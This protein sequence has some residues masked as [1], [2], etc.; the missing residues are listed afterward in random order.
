MKVQNGSKV[1]VHYTGK[2]EDGTIFDTSDGREPLAFTVGEGQMIPGFEKGVMDLA[3]GEKKTVTIPPEEAYG[4]PQE[5]MVLTVEKDKVFPPE[6]D[7]KVG[8]QYNLTRKDGGTLPVT[9][10]NIVDEKVTL[11]ANHHLAGKT[12]IFD[13]EVVELA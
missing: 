1:K 8:E 4:Q 6:I 9:V 7:P 3:V 12:L 10:T 13:I 11:D 2:L 5:N